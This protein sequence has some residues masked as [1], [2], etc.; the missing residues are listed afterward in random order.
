VSAEVIRF[1]TERRLPP[2]L[3]TLT[4]LRVYLGMSERWIRYQIASGLPVHRYGNRLR[5]KV[6]EVES[7]LKERERHGA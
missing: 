4:E 2:Q 1:P 3:L 7:W 6:D 5:F